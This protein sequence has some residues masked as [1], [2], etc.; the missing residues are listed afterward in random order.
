MELE[1]IAVILKFGFLAVLYLTLIWVAR[2]SLRDL[3][4][5][6]PGSDGSGVSSPGA[7]SGMPPPEAFLV[8][9]EGAGLDEGDRIDLFGGVTIGRGD[10][11]DLTLRDDFSSN[12]HARV[13]AREGAYWVEDLG[14]TNGTFLN[15]EQVS[16]Q[17]RLTRDDR[18]RIGDTEFRY[19]A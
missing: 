3:R 12:M 14:S 9:L 10:T 11:A 6:G 15:A 8:V 7:G 13:L 19:E 17:Q 16:G 4:R 2:S 5:A 18:I 1:P